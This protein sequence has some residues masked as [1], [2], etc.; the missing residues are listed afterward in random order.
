MRF[1]VHFS[2]ANAPACFQLVVNILKKY[3]WKTCL[4]YLDDVIVFSKNVNYHSQH[5]D[6]VLIA[7]NKGDVTVK[8]KVL[9][10]PETSQI[11]GTREKTR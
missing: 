9:L 1:Y 3:K 11:P 5:V 7:M 10:L 8:I 4:V 2:I 6:E